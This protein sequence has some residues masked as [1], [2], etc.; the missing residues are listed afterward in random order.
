[1]RFVPIVAAAF[2]ALLPFTPS[3]HAQ[4]ASNPVV[5]ATCGSPP[6]AYIA[7]L[8]SPGTVDTTGKACVNATVS[9]TATTTATAASTPPTV[10]P[11]PNTPLAVN[12]TSG[13]YTQDTFAGT[14]VD[15][16]HGLPVNCIVGCASGS[17]YTNSNLSSTISVS[18]TFQS[19]Q[20]STS[21]HGCTIQ[22]NGAD[23]LWV[24]FGA[25]GSATK[26]SAIALTV[27]QSVSCAVGGTGV[28]TD[29]ISVTGTASDTFYASVQ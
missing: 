12:L 28:A 14:P 9:A 24:Y 1:M 16:T 13:L 6:T 4:T 8:P 20:V 23:P 19:V 21:R 17:S 29:Q 10:S 7:G 26:A 15:G 11:G 5:V 2:F 27:G 22:A 25:I 3:A 18:N